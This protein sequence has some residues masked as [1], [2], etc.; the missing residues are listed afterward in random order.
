[1]KKY[2]K[3]LLLPNRPVR[4]RTIL[5]PL[6][7][8]CP[9]L[10]PRTSLRYILGLYE[11]ELNPWLKRSIP[12]VNTLWDIG[13]NH[14]YFCF[15]VMAA[16]HRQGRRGNVHAFEPQNEVISLLNTASKWHSWPGINLNIEQ[17]LVGR[18]P[19]EGCTS[20]NDY[21]ARKCINIKNSRSLIKIDVEGA[22]LEVLEG[23]D[24]LV[25]DDNRF[26]VEIHS[27]ALLQKVTEFFSSRGHRV[28]VVSQRALPLIGRECRDVDNWWVVSRI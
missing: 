25:N 11:H 24:M 6:R 10:V 17:C 26:L 8:G 1:M 5:G 2:V 9:L 28:D 18:T 15:G 19:S 20:I 3:N 7:G 23:A 16:W 13:A 4:C 21:I 22:E 12:E 14:G 27:S